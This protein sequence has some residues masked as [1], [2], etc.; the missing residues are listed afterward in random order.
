MYILGLYNKTKKNRDKSNHI[1]IRMNS[2]R[3]LDGQN[4]ITTLVCNNYVSDKY[5][6]ISGGKNEKG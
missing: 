5:D 4:T 3:T 2:E 6:I 1:N